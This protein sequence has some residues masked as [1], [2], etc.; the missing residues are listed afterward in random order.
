MLE[1]SGRPRVIL[2]NSIMYFG[3]QAGLCI[4]LV[5]LYGIIGAAFARIISVVF[6][7]L[8]L[9]VEVHF[10]LRMNPFRISLYKPMLSGGISCLLLILLKDYL[11]I[12]GGSFTGLALGSIIFIGA[13]GMILWSL[14][15]SEED[16]MILRKVRSKLAF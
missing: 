8:V 9:L 10:L 4:V 7:R 3:I 15:F 11:S 6:M 12:I 1:M 13:Y 5:S 14:G 16:K 2:I